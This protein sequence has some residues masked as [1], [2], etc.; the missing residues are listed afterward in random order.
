MPLPGG[1]GFPAPPPTLAG[2][3]LCASEALTDPNFYRSV[4]FIAQHNPQGALGLILNRPT[5]G[6]LQ[7]L[8]PGLRGSLLGKEGFSIGGPVQ[9]EHLFVL[10]QEDARVPEPFPGL[11]P[12]PGVVFEPLTQIFFD[13]LRD[14]SPED[15]PLYRIFAGYAGWSSDQ[16]EGELEESAWYWFP[17]DKDDLF[18][19]EP[20]NLYPQIMHRG[21]PV[22]DLIARTGHRVCLN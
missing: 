22:L 15:Q 6:T 2:W 8:F 3:H 19:P 10:R 1:L 9:K 17:G 13:Y 11:R 20:Q 16:L 14:S 12:L 7:D 18:V 4:V 5:N 21:G